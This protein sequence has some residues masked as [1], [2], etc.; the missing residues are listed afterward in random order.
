[1]TDEEMKEMI[2]IYTKDLGFIP[3]DLHILHLL[4]REVEHTVRHKA[5]S[6]AYDLAN[7]INNLK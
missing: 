4:C 3:D 7:N 1:M 5:V 2:H 6:M